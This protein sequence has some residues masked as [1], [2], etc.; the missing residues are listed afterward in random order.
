MRCRSAASP[1]ALAPRAGGTHD[2]PQHSA[3]TPRRR[4]RD[5]AAASG[6]TRPR[7]P[8]SCASPRRVNA[9]TV[10]PTYVKS[11][12][13]STF[14]S[15]TVSPARSCVTMVGM[16]AR[17]DCRGP[18]VL[19]GRSVAT[20]RPKLRWNDSAILSAPIL[21]AAYG[22]CPCRG[23]ASSMGTYFALPYTSL[24]DV[25]TNRSTP[26]S[27]AARSTLSVPTTFVSTLAAVAS[28]DQGIA[29]RAVR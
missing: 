23:C 10:S 26:A 5:D 3:P 6:G 4:S 15:A 2:L 13:G 1:V 12:V 11:R 21:L 29:I 7:P 16:T 19:N 17:A 25:W 8:T 20:G 9:S 27:C 18:Y 14:P 24:V 22:D 28:Y